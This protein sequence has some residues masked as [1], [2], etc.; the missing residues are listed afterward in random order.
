[1]DGYGGNRKIQ[2]NPRNNKDSGFK[3][4]YEL[5]HKNAEKYMI[6]KEILYCSASRKMGTE[7]VAGF[8][9]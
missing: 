7:V 5:R 8:W 6:R 1:L 9:F 4:P 3:L 2:E